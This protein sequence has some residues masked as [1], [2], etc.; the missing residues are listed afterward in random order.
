MLTPK[1]DATE[2][3]G[4]RLYAWYP[5]ISRTC[6]RRRPSTKRT[7]IPLCFASDGASE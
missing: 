5:S 6:Q 2:Q 1:G 4:L 7:Q 3:K